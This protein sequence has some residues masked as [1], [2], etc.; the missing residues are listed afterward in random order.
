MVVNVRLAGFWIEVEPDIHSTLSQQ[1]LLVR[2]LI[3]RRLHFADDAEAEIM[4]TCDDG[5]A[6]ESRQDR[7][8]AELPEMLIEGER[9]GDAEFLQDEPCWCSR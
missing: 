4:V 8:A 3:L 9:R 1:P 7:D 5:P 6:F 2:S